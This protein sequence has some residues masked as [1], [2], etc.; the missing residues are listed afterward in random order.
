MRYVGEARL[1]K[2]C[3]LLTGTDLTVT[4]VA[5]RCGYRDPGYF[6]RQFRKGRAR[7]AATS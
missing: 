2:A 1:S 7:R 3:E 5:A 4:E 6:A